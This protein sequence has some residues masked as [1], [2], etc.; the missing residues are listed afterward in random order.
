MKNLPS[1]YVALAIMITVV[2]GCGLS[3]YKAR[4]SN[5]SANSGNS[6]GNNKSL[7]EH[8]VDIALGEK[9]IGIPECDEI[10]AFFNRQIEN[11]DDDMVTKAVKRTALNK[12]KEQ[13]KAS[14]EKDK[15]NKAEMAKT[16]REFKQN[17]EMYGAESANG[18]N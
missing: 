13:F 15:S 1:F 18:N 8:G 17:L 7:T 10:V 9:E 2:L 3:D 14:L 16:C 12:F 5:T 11:P 6:A 4:R